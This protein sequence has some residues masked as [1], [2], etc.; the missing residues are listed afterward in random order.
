MPGLDL[1][2]AFLNTVDERT[3]RRHGQNHV[4]AEQLTGPEALTAWLTSHDLPTGEPDLAAALALR[5]ALRQA[6]T[7]G[8]APTLADF[9]LYLV[10]DGSG[11]LDLVART[12]RPWLD[13]LVETV[14]RS[15]WSRLKLCAAEDCRWAFHDTS[16]NGRGRWCDME[17]CGNRHKTRTYRV[18]RQA[19]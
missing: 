6:L 2:E 14:A 11:G 17:V 13:T 10:P 12:G 19:G 4:A 15:D 18:R 8:D 9:P 1:I 5:T 3:F 16:R 7:G